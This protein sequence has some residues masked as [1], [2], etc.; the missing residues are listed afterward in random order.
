MGAPQGGV[1]AIFSYRRDLFG[2]PGTTRVH[3][4]HV[5]DSTFTSCAS[6]SLAPKS[7]A[8]A[9]SVALWHPDVVHDGLKTVL[10]KYA[11][12][13]EQGA[14]ASGP[15]TVKAALPALLH[16]STTAISTKAEA[17]DAAIRG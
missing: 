9:R 3:P 12:S 11:R 8:A 13:G 7:K 17:A 10:A 16:A 2:E 4:G 1:P 14:V 6:R 15:P 5:P